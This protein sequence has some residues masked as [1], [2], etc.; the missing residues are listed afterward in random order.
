MSCKRRAYGPPL[1][2]DVRPQ[3]TPVYHPETA[4]ELAI[5]ESLLEAH[6]IPYFVH[7]RGFAGLYPGIQL[8]LL[9]ARTI[10]VPP[11]VS[12]LAKEVLAE[13]LADTSGVRQNRE[14]SLWHI[15]RLIFETLSMGWCV[16]RVGNVSGQSLEP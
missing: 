10:L 13:Y 8:N 15:L 9:N 14:R 2:S 5:A 16:P 1:I 3:V 6:Q 11:S 4:I 12:E 7:N